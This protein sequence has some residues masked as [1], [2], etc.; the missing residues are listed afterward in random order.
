MRT[1]QSPGVEIKEIDQSLRPV[2]P[3]GT[4]ILATGFSDRGP[5]DEVIQ[6]TSQSEFEQI[7]GTPRTPAERYF[8]HTV[9]PLFQS[10]ANILTYRLPYGADRGV[11]FG[12]NYG[13]LAY[14][15]SAFYVGDTITG[16]LSFGD[17]LSTLSQSNTGVL[18][19]FGKPTHIELSQEQYFDIL[20]FPHFPKNA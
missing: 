11:G 17:Q 10:P 20:Q 5:T 16:S 1:I 9:R 19:V 2:L 7:Y 14:T 8:Y 15:V 3:A 4:N 6:V 12:N 18:Y 13:T